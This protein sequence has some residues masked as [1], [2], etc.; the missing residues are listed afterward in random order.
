MPR[1]SGPQPQSAEVIELHGNPGHLS[2]AEIEARR[3][4]PKPQPLSRRPPSGLSPVA[5]EIWEEHARELEALGLLSVLD[6]GSFRLACE[7]YALA[8]SALESMRPT[9]ADGTPDERRRGYEP[10]TVDKAHRGDLRR[11]PGFVIYKQASADYRSWAVEFGLTPSARVSLRP[12]LPTGSEGD[13][14][15]GDGA[16]GDFF[17]TG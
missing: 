7:S 17:G 2:A 8:I 9:K 15:D 11:H 3:Q 5:R 4:I 14:G 10:V 16:A 1:K 6:S 13:S 12:S